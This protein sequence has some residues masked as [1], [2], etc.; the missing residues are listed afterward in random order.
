LAEA[1][2][3]IGVMEDLVDYYFGAD[4]EVKM[5]LARP[6]LQRRSRNASF[7]L[8]AAQVRAKCCHMP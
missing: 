7:L 2:R 5:K 8:R 4:K 1:E 3:Q 6:R